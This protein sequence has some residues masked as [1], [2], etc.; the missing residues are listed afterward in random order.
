[1]GHYFMDT[2]YNFLM[3]YNSKLDTYPDK[4]FSVLRKANFFSFY[5]IFSGLVGSRTVRQGEQYSS[6]RFCRQSTLRP[7][8]YQSHTIIRHTVC[9]GSSDPFYIVTYYIKWVTT[10]WIYSRNGPDILY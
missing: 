4:Y 10:S 8:T 9:P 7:G 5:K 6:N 2:Q 3:K 1:M